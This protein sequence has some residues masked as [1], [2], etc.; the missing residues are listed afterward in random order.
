[1]SPLR[2][3]RNALR[4]EIG[5]TAIQ[6]CSL[7]STST[8]KCDKLTL[9][10]DINGQPLYAGN[11]AKLGPNLGQTRPDAAASLCLVFR[12]VLYSFTLL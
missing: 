1:M 7:L 8:G 5:H 12:H 10:A 2:S 3:W 4:A 11:G 6:S 9:H